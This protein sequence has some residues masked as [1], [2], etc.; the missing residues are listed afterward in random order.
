MKKYREAISDIGM[1][2]RVFYNKLNNIKAALPA[3]EQDTPEEL[4]PLP[5]I[6]LHWQRKNERILRDTG[7]NLIG[8]DFEFGVFTMGLKRLN[9]YI[10]EKNYSQLEKELTYMSSLRG[11]WYNRFQFELAKQ[12]LRDLFSDDPDGSARIKTVAAGFMNGPNA[13]NVRSCKALFE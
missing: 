11:E 1:G 2:Q 12:N 3:L 10:R 9:R 13:S 5:E 4:H 7:F 8:D 6:S